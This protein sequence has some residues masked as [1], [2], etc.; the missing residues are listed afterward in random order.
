MF[1]TIAH[2]STA[3]KREL[4]C[5]VIGHYHPLP[6]FFS[7]VG[8]CSPSISKRT[9][10]PGLRLHPTIRREETLTGRLVRPSEHQGS[11]DSR[12]VEQCLKT[13]MIPTNMLAHSFTSVSVPDSPVWPSRLMIIPGHKHV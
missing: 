9:G 2:D 13:D 4:L 6:G 11:G 3:G 8:R 5:S 1:L 7:M 12:L 10:A